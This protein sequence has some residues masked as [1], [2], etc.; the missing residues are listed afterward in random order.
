[1]ARI[2]TDTAVGFVTRAIAAVLARLWEPQTTFAEVL[3]P[4]T[5]FHSHSFSHP[6]THSHS[7]SFS[8]ILTPAHSLA[9][10]LT[11]SISLS[12]TPKQVECVLTMLYELGEVV[13]LDEAVSENPEVL[14]PPIN[15]RSSHNP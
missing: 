14:T 13:R 4:F 9:L 11:H 12:L 8:L 10:T 2:S 3:P 15:P 7:L 1:M 5:L 6:P